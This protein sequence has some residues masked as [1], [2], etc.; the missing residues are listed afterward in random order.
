MLSWT[1]VGEADDSTPVVKA[2]INAVPEKTYPNSYGDIWV[3]TWADDDN[4]YTVCGDGWGFG[5]YQQWDWRYT[6]VVLS[7]LAGSDPDNLN[8]T[9]VHG[10]DGYSIFL[11]DPFDGSVKTMGI[12]CIDGV[13]YVALNGM[14][15]VGK[16]NQSIPIPSVYAWSAHNCTIVESTDHGA[17]WT[18]GPADIGTNYTFPGIIFPTASFINYGKDGTNRPTSDQSDKYVYLTSNDTGWSDGD[19]YMLARILRSRLPY[20]DP[21]D[22]E[23][24][25]GGDGM[26]D[27]NWTNDPTQIGHIIDNPGKCG[28]SC[29]QYNTVLKRYI[30]IGWF[31]T[32][33]YPNNEGYTTLS[34]YES[35]T[36]W[37]PWNVVGLCPTY[38]YGWYDPG[39]WE[40]FTSA[41]GKTMKLAVGSAAY[42]PLQF[43]SCNVLTMNLYTA[44]DTLPPSPK[45]SNL[46]LLKPV[47]ASSAY[48]GTPAYAAERVNDGNKLTRTYYWQPNTSSNEWVVVDFGRTE[49]VNRTEI[50][51]FSNVVQ[52]YKIQYWDQTSS[53]WLD[54]VTNGGLIGADKVDNFPEIQTSKLR[55]YIVGTTNNQPIQ[56]LEFEAFDMDLVLHATAGNA[57]A[58]LSW[59]PSSGAISYNVKRATVSGGPYTVIA[60]G[61]TATNYI[62]T[63]LNNGTT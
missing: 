59:N 47:T 37:G 45:N 28:M 20:L 15:A 62:D 18:P 43:V 7:S 16:Q 52:N 56:I 32:E 48:L 58:S 12:T 44:A 50:F 41:D 23:F 55:L 42:L 6:Q 29:V 1:S 49:S 30:M 11:T 46:N 38:P 35:P 27:Q 2:T 21:A 60:N 51:E 22:Y 33:D 54:A 5:Y 10:L 3:S 26:L 40:K 13:L 24:Y 25:M 36:P 31:F 57:Q 53:S 8:G 63:G 39:I 61:V 17:T 19:Y 4:T 9:V 34:V 14:G